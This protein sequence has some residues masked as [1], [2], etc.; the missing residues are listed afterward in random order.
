ML[1]KAQ[2]VWLCFQCG[3]DHIKKH[4]DICHMDQMANMSP[5]HA[6]QVSFKYLQIFCTA[7]VSP[8]ISFYFS[9]EKLP[10]YGRLFLDPAE[11]CSLL[12]Q[13]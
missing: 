9:L 4:L 5:D 13:R 2:H 3:F 6:K 10:P 1:H 11:G 8:Y 12:L 7:Y